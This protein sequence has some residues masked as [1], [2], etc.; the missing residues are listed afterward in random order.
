MGAP[1][2]II[3]DVRDEGFVEI[4][5]GWMVLVGVELEL[6]LAEVRLGHARRPQE[7]PG[8]PVQVVAI[9]LLLVR[10]VEQGLVVEV[11]D[12]EQEEGV[13]G[14]Q[15]LRRVVYVE[16]WVGGG[17]LWFH[18]PLELPSSRKSQQLVAK[19]SSKSF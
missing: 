7:A 3:V 9:V 15:L 8:H 6:D 17:V 19:G 18:S 16:F 4:G 14:E 11:E 10:F 13:R 5:F 1:E 12:L 2:E